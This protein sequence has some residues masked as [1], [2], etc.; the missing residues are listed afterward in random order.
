MP[1][2]FSC[3]IF[4]LALFAF[5]VSP[6]L[7]QTRTVE[8]TLGAF[9]VP[10]NPTRI[11]TTHHAATQPLLDLDVVPVGRG[12][13]DQAYTTS[14]QWEMI[15]D[16]P[17]V[18]LEGGEPNYELIAT[19][20]PDLIFEVNIASQDRI[21]RLSEIA[22]VVVVGLRVGWQEKAREAA[23]I[24][25]AL[26]RWEALEAE[27]AARQAQIAADYADILTENT[28]GVIG[29]WNFDIPTVWPSNTGLGSILQPAGA[30]YGSAIE[31]LPTEG[32]TEVTISLEDI[33][34]VLG[35]VDI[36]FY[37]S[38]IDG[39]LINE[40]NQRL[41]DHEIFQRLPA[42]AE[43]RVFPIGM[44]TVGSFATAHNTLDHYVAALEA[45]AAEV[46]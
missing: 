1:P 44:I 22:P 3:R 36:L 40:D 5:A 32:V 7:A 23:E 42:V 8:T 46:Q 24:V 33:S 35:D 41:R 21:E 2:A 31:A 6:V 28:I 10:E 25:N 4:G 9:E 34:A 43:G 39:S 11:V 16:V 27:Y 45:V 12:A 13:V 30:V 37:N 26:D 15:A 19:L 38:Y 20:E 18:T 29:V 14:D 17:T